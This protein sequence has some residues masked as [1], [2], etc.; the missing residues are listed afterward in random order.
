M[1][2][3]TLGMVELVALGDEL[4][5]VFVIWLLGHL[6]RL[7][8]SRCRQRG[9]TI[10]FQHYYATTKIYGAVAIH[11]DG[12]V[13]CIADLIRHDRRA[14]GALCVVTPNRLASVAITHNEIAGP[15]PLEHKPCGRG[16]NAAVVE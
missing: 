2:A 1:T 6:C 12:Y 3:G 4:F 5:A 11:Q 15:F 14:K 8:D 9:L 7:D 16:E 13:L 10:Q